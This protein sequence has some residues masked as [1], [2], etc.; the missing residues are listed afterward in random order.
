MVWF[1]L[2]ATLNADISLT[3]LVVILGDFDLSR[4]VQ[5]EEEVKHGYSTGACNNYWTTNLL[6]LKLDE[7]E[8]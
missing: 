1:S 7:N 2:W 5:E 6:L 8:K 3:S 4:L